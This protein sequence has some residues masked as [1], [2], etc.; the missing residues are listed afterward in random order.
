MSLTE[1]CTHCGFHQP[2]HSA[3]CPRVFAPVTPLATA[4]DRD[5]QALRDRVERIDT[6][7]RDWELESEHRINAALRRIEQ[8]ELEVAKLKGPTSI[9]IPAGAIVDIE[10]LAHGRV[11]FFKPDTNCPSCGHYNGHAV[12]CHALHSARYNEAVAAMSPATA[13][14]P[15]PDEGT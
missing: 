14:P 10:K 9:T 11:V 8:L 6:L 12:D 4:Y 1:L 5:Q 15:L 13:Y 2:E 3:N 7:R